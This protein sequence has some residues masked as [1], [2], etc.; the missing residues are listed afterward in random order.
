MSVRVVPATM[1]TNGTYFAATV[2]E[3]NRR[4]FLVPNSA[5]LTWPAFYVGPNY[6]SARLSWRIPQLQSKGLRVNPTT[7]LE[8]NDDSA[9]DR[10]NIYRS[11]KTSRLWHRR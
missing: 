2:I 4:Y 9:L 7:L 6:F 1:R 8:V 11:N 3:N 5:L 10:P